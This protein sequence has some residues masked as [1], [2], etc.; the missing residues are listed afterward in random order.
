MANS[1]S[2]TDIAG[3]I[4]IGDWL[5]M[6]AG[7]ALVILLFTTLW[8]G[9]EASKLQIR[10]GNEV[11][12]TY[13]LDQARIIE[14]PGPLGTSII[15]IAHGKARVVSDP[16][17]KQYCIKQGWLAQAGQVAMCL[18]NQVSIQLLGNNKPY[19]SLSY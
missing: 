9:R 15:E 6:V 14:V 1:T 19:D 16:G 5:M 17:P 2:S 10:A 3:S 4:R 11:F 7:S 8:Q 12:G 13:S 18:P